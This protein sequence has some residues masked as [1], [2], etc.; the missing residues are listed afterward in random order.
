V[1]KKE[2][3]VMGFSLIE[4]WHTMGI[5]AKLV[6]LSLIVMAV[7]SLTVVFERLF[8]LRRTGKQ[9]VLFAKQASPIVAEAKFEDLVPLAEQ[10]PKSPLARLIKMGANHYIAH[11]FEDERAGL[12]PVE[13]TK[14]EMHRQGETISAELRSGMGLLASVGSVA[15]F[16]GLFGTV[17]GII[18]A[19]EGIAKTGSGGL[20]S[21]SAGIAEALLVTAL[22]LCVAIPAVLFFNYLS[23]KIDRVELKLTNAAGEFL[24]EVE[25]S[26]GY[27]NRSSGERKAA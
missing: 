7:A 9:S 22:G 23:A 27:L 10:Y 1:D 24:D 8:Y 25:K 4:I 26:H 18:T 2:L 5:M 15:P 19:F 20:G 21:V 16:V 17:V 14:R 6:A 11:L 13:A 3:T 12:D